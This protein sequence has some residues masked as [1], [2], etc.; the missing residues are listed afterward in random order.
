MVL[1][2]HA[3]VRGDQ[4]GRHAL[5]VDE[6]CTIPPGVSFTLEAAPKSELLEVLVAL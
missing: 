2:G 6:A 3:D 1:S 4:I 5:S